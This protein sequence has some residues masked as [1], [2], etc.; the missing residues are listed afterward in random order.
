M[1]KA[2]YIKV[3]N[4]HKAEIVSALKK[5]FESDYW[6]TRYNIK[7][8]LTHCLDYFYDDNELAHNT[9]LLLKYSQVLANIGYIEAAGIVFIDRHVS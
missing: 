1:L 6:L 4:K 9:N 5:I 3:F 2:L 8:K 7:C